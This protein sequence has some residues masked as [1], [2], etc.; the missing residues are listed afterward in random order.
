M[1]ASAGLIH[2]VARMLAVAAANSTL[3]PE[4]EKREAD[5]KKQDEQKKQDQQQQRQQ[6]PDQA[7][8]EIS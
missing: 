2:A 3:L 5:K 7:K 1:S 4:A 8:P 6:K